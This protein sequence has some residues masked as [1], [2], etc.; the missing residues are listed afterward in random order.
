M[1]KTRK[2]DPQQAQA[3]AKLAAQVTV[4]LQVEL[5]AKRDSLLPPRQAIGA[6]SLGDETTVNA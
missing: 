4:S 6:L 1:V 5:N 3:I 2:M